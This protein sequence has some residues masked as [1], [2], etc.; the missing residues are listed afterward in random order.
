[1]SSH[2]GCLNWSYFLILYPEKVYFIRS[3]SYERQKFSLV[4]NNE[5][6][7]MLISADFRRLTIYINKKRNWSL[8][9]CMEIRL[10][11]PAV[12]HHYF[13]GPTPI[14]PSKSPVCLRRKLAQLLEFS[15][16]RYRAYRM[17][18]FSVSRYGSFLLPSIIGAIQALDINQSIFSR[19]LTHAHENFWQPFRRCDMGF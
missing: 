1:M 12:A 9:C 11:N 18:M 7:F 17:S 15:P 13:R 19:T 2:F 5:L 3:T 8:A 10:C 6:R 4:G 16:S 14:G